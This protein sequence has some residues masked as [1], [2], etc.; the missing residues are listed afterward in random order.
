MDS[1][2]IPIPWT[3]QQPPLPKPTMSRQ[4]SHIPPPLFLSFYFI[5]IY[6]PTHLTL[7]FSRGKPHFSPPLLCMHTYRY[8]IF[9]Y[10]VEDFSPT[11]G[12]FCMF[13]FF[14]IYVYKKGQGEFCVVLQYVEKG[15]R[16][17]LSLSLT[18]KF[19]MRSGEIPDCTS[20]SR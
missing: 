8:T 14:N 1:K 13:F 3:R 10:R 16:S 5:E 17:S 9:E 18:T 12:V 6:Y 7:G 15:K 2:Q 4:I 20:H 19:F 11:D